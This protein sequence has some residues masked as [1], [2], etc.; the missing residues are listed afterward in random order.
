MLTAQKEKVIMTTSLVASKPTSAD[1][2]RVLLIDWT[3]AAARLPREPTPPL[4]DVYRRLSQVERATIRVCAPA[5]ASL[6][7]HNSLIGEGAARLCAYGDSGVLQFASGHQLARSLQY[8]FNLHPM[9][10]RQSRK[11][12]SLL[13]LVDAA[14]IGVEIYTSAEPTLDNPTRFRH[15]RLSARVA[16]LDH[17]RPSRRAALV[18][19]GVK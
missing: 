8:M 5:L 4:P 11:G 9:A 2:N 10:L 6:T 7:L 18:G 12:W 16:E 17:S 13:A 19:N 1:Q 15:L 14:D 3:L